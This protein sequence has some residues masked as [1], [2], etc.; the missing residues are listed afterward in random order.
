MLV[1][2][3]QKSDSVLYMCVW[4]ACVLFQILFHYMLLQDTEYS[5]LCYTAVQNKKLYSTASCLSVLYIVA[6]SVNP[7]S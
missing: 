4:C 1:S 3:V 6:L 2:G 7:N 5:S